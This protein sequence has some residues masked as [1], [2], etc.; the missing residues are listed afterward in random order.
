V[1]L[2]PFEIRN[3]SDDEIKQKMEETHKELFNLRFQFVIGQVKDT[4]IIRKLKKNIARLNTI[5]N[6]RQFAN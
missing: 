3:L 1:K 5:L 4:S 6:E 2:K